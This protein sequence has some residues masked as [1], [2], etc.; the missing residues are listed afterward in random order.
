MPKTT[1]V[2]RPKKVQLYLSERELV[3][4]QYIRGQT[5]A[6][7]DS[8]TI[9]TAIRHRAIELREVEKNNGAEVVIERPDGTKVVIVSLSIRNNSLDQSGRAFLL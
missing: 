6:G 3:D 2:L 4:L 5:G 1:T 8:E 9:R 7:T